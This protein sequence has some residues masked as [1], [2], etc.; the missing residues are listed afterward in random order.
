MT[1]KFQNSKAR[2]RRRKGKKKVVKN[3][4]EREVKKNFSTAFVDVYQ[5]IYFSLFEALKKNVEKK[6]FKKAVPILSEL[7]NEC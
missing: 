6:K 7:K 1:I 5:V 4:K 3:R 2:K